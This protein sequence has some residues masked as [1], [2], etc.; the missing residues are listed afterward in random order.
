MVYK[1]FVV[2]TCFIYWLF[3]FALP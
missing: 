1:A 2:F 3:R